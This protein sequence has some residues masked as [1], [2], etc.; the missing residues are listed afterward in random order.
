MTAITF[1]ALCAL[2]HD[3]KFGR[4]EADETDMMAHVQNRAAEAEHRE[5]CQFTLK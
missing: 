5:V 1:C 4:G 2:Q 3:F